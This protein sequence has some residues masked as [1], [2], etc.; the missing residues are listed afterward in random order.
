MPQKPSAK[1]SNTRSRRNL[2]LVV[3]LLIVGLL[4]LVVTFAPLVME[5]QDSA[6][7]TI[8]TPAPS[9]GASSQSLIVLPDDGVAVVLELIERAQESI[10]LKIYLMTYRD[11]RAALIR[12]ANRGVDVR[13]IIEKNPTGGGDSNQISYDEL[14]DGGVSVKWAPAT[15]RLTHEKSLVIDDRE[16]LFGTFNYT[17]SSFSSNREYGVRLDDPS[18]V[19]D[20]ASIFDADWDAVGI[21]LSDDSPLVLSPTNSRDRIYD[22]VDGAEQTLWLEQA[23]LLD[24]D[25]TD[26]LI[27]AVHRGVEVRFIG[28]DRGGADDYAEANYERLRQAGAQVALLGDPQIHA[29]VILADGERAL[30]GSINMT[31]A[32]ME[33]NRELGILTQDPDVV[34]RLQDTMANDWTQASKIVVAPEGVIP[35]DEARHFVGADVTLEGEIVRTYDSGKVTFLNFD[36][37]YRNTLSIVIFPDAYDLFP[38]PPAEHFLDRRIQVEGRVKEYQGAPEIIVETARQIQIMGDDTEDNSQTVPQVTRT[39]APIPD[40]VPWQDAI[41][42]VGEDITIEGAVV[43]TYDS[44]N[45]T[46]L[47]FSNNW[48]GTMSVVIFAADYEKFPEPPES[49]YLNQELH[50]SGRVKEYKGAP[51]IVVES[52]DQIEIV[53]QTMPSSAEAEGSAGAEVSEGAEDSA[54][55]EGSES[56]ESVT[57]IISWQE[58]DAHVGQELTVEGRIVRANDTGSITFLNFSKKKGGF[59]AVVFADDYDNFGDLPVRLYDGKEVWISGEITAYKGTP[60]IVVRS[61]EQVEVFE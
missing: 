40:I 32:S 43:R 60:Q 22:I 41:D 3:T 33:L 21:E 11:I 38:T 1:Q 12:A 42:Y 6:A 55:A 47:N 10:R 26:R 58:A 7:E 31:F 2:A 59:V 56:A 45:V 54:P 49:L 28:A 20:I 18:I 25:V 4:L 51:E 29:K 24:E 36:D 35:W 15:F 61:P 44:G 37:D 14:V 5:T 50:V 53:G 16:A 57:G 30:I 46:F 52:P 9:Q 23:T 13:V 48:Q 17:V 19:D 39:E 27:Q 8:D 34:E